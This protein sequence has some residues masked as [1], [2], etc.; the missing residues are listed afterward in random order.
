MPSAKYNVITAKASPARL[1][2]AWYRLPLALATVVVAIPFLVGLWITVQTDS[3]VNS[4]FLEQREVELV[5]R[6]TR[7]G[8]ETMENLLVSADLVLLE[9]RRYW[10]N[11]PEEFQ[12]VLQRRHN[13]L[14]LGSRFDVFVVDSRGSLVQSANSTQVKPEDNQYNTL[15]SRHS[16][17][18]QDQLLL[19]PAFFESTSQSWQLPFTRRL[20]TSTGKFIG[21]IVFLVPHDYFNQVLQNNNLNIDS[22]FSIADLQTGDVI[23]RSTQVNASQTSAELADTNPHTDAAPATWQGFWAPFNLDDPEKVPGVMVSQ[24]PPPIDRLTGKALEFVNALPAIG[25][26][27][28]VSTVDKIERIYA[29]DKLSRANV[30]MSFGSPTSE[31]DALQSLNWWRHAVAGAAFSLL[32]FFLSY[33]FN[34]YDRLRR[35][36]QHKLKVSEQALRSLAAHQTGLLE[37]ERKFIAREIHDDLGQRITVLRLDLAI[38]IQAMPDNSSAELLAR[39]M[40]LKDDVDDLLRV[41]RGLAQKVRPPLLDIGFIAAIEGLCEEFQ[42]RL[43]FKLRL[44][45]FA[46]PTYQPPDA[47]AIAAYRILQESLSNAARHSQCQHI[48]V[49]LAVH[50]DCLH[51]RVSDDGIGFDPAAPTSR[52]TFGLLGMRERVAALNGEMR[53]QSQVGLGCKLLVVLPAHAHGSQYPN[54]DS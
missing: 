44:V 45:N 18:T 31:F 36:N 29:W 47:C 34:F 46:D 22:V 49:S 51:L 10:Q 2:Q 4:Q 52:H 7:L 50:D 17:N 39:P 6:T 5:T 20:L 9:L 33:G 38:L 42:N 3:A 1:L 43:P 25:V 21:I 27:R 53:L 40:Q 32:I 19:G 26:D 24:L 16:K 8:A 12:N 54:Q 14:Q 28:L 35:K 37:D 11:H 30:V 48:D 15:W 41:T 13:T 23:L